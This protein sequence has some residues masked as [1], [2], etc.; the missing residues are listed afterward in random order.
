VP[1]LVTHGRR[2]EIVLPSMADHVLD[3]CPTAVASWYDEVGHAPFLEDAGRFD[4][5]LLALA[6]RS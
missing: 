2:D 1:V 4:R 5:E 3:V 6:R